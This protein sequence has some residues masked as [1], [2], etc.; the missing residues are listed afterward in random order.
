MAVQ[1]AD[2]T[3]IIDNEPI[4][5]SPNTIKFTEGFGEQTVRTMAVGGGEV[6]LL[7]ANN[8]ET[9]FSKLMFEMPSTIDNIALARKWKAK[10][11]TIVAQVTGRTTE[12]NF[13][14]TIRKSAMVNDHEVDISTEVNIPVEIH[15]ARAV[16]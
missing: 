12:G 10:G 1:V 14:R 3:L 2:A 5:Y 4:G 13:T 8:Q 16:G 6:E 7:F 15:G 9:S 11:D